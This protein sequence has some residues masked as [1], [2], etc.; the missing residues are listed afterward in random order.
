M[1]LRQ[2]CRVDIRERLD[3]YE[4][5]A[6][7]CRRRLRLVW[8]EPE[9]SGPDAYTGTPTADTEPTAGSDASGRRAPLAIL[10]DYRITRVPARKAAS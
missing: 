2:T 10:D 1:G 3:G 6:L 7:P 4:V 5:T 8:A 9:R